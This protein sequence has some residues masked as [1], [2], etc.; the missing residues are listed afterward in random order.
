MCKT[1]VW[2]MFQW[3]YVCMRCVW[4]LPKCPEFSNS[5]IKPRFDSK[6]TKPVLTANGFYADMGLNKMQCMNVLFYHLSMFDMM[7][8][9]F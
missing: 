6:V 4:N 3:I 9:N 1:E 7:L 8:I 2:I 5:P